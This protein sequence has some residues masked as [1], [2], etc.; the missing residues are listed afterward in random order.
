MSPERP[1]IL[2]MVGGAVLFGQERANIDTLASLRDAGCDV[3]CLTRSHYWSREVSD[4][5]ARRG[6]DCVPVRYMELWR[7][8]RRW[9]F[10]LLNWLYLPW[11]SLQFLRHFRRFRPTH[12]YSC[13]Q[14]YVVNFAPA[15]WLV[16]TPLLYRA[17][18]EPTLHNRAWR[19]AWR[20]VRA[21]TARFVAISRFIRDRLV[22]TGVPADRIDVVYNGP[23]PR[24]ATPD[25]RFAAAK[26]KALRFSY[27]GQ[28]IPEKGVDV[29]VEAFRSLVAAGA[30]ADLLV[31]GRIS[32]W[33]GDRWARA[34][35]DRCAADPLTRDR[36]R[37]LGHVDDV[38]GLLAFADVHVAP[39]LCNE[40]LGLVVMEAK[41]AGR[42][43]IVFANGALPE[44]VRGGIDGEVCATSDAEG[45]AAAMRLY[46]DRRARAAE[47]G[48]AA[49]D[50]L[51]RFGI[52]RLG[53]SW[54]EAIRAAARPAASASGRPPA[55]RAR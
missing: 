38:A 30:D 53:E 40:A 34:L 55:A 44:L 6:L 41:A 18:D 36:I 20:A 45:L 51:A 28:L 5:F 23:P 52:D 14:V 1:R 46:L 16:P 27:H 50:S 19:L 4:E 26:G 54:L 31:A 22:A 10:L 21:R 13:S 24:A 25:P 3:L 42:P 43:S 47:H 11:A 9:H 29:L 49:R 7:P 2:A 8:G 32:G 12:L 48:A 33:E 35:R 37:F 17:G 15:L 39:S